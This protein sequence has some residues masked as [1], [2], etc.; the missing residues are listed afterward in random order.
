MLLPNQRNSVNNFL[1]LGI[2]RIPHHKCNTVAY[3]M[4]PLSAQ[5]LEVTSL[6]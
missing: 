5:R 2:C 3:M 1:L 6:K 4:V